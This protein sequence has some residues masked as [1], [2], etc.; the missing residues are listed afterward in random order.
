MK[1]LVACEESQEVCKAFRALGHEAYSCDLQDCSGGH[2]EWHI[3]GTDM[4]VQISI[5]EAIA[6]VQETVDEFSTFSISKDL[7]MFWHYPLDVVIIKLN[8]V[9]EDA[10]AA[11][12]AKKEECQMQIKELESEL[13]Q[14]EFDMEINK[15]K[16]KMHN[17]MG[18]FHAAL[19]T[20]W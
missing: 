18:E 19:P 8:R 20:A 3:R 11:Y 15:M 17:A 5:D 1:A 13:H 10:E 7:E 4:T 2:P 6:L 16:M 14:K 9:K 12:E